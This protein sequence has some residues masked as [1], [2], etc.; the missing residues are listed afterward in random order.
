MK[1]ASAIVY[2]SCAAAAIA[3][4]VFGGQFAWKTFEARQAASAAEVAAMAENAEARTPRGLQRSAVLERMHDPASA[5]FR[6]IKE[7]R[8]APGTWCG[9]VNA[10]NKMGGMVG[11]TRY[12][13]E[14]RFI[15]EEYSSSWVQLDDRDKDSFDGK[16][17][18]QIWQAICVPE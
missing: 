1:M 4:G 17:F 10:K 5:V 14:L 12:I 6:N 11:F 13:V 7:V 16:S 9:E 3:A 2:S 8:F 18:E 15:G